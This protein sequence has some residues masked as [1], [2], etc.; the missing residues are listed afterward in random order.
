MANLIFP[1]LWFMLIFSFMLNI[2]GIRKKKS[3]KY[4]A[5]SNTKFT[6]I[7]YGTSPWKNIPQRLSIA[8]YSLTNWCVACFSSNQVIRELNKTI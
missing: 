4:V 3:N 2:L 6:Q 5:S 7:F 8:H 1:L